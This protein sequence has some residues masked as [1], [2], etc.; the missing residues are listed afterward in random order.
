MIEVHILD[1]NVL[2]KEKPSTNAHKLNTAKDMEDS[3]ET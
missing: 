3:A 2:C 1:F